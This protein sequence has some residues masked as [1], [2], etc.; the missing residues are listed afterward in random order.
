VC[1]CRGCPRR[2]GA[3]LGAAA[4]GDDVAGLVVDRGHAAFHQI[5]RPGDI[6]LVRGFEAVHNGLHVRVHA[7][8]DVHRHG[9]RII[10][11]Q[12]LGFVD[13]GV[14]VGLIGVAA[15]AGA[16]L[17]ARVDQQVFDLDRFRQLAFRLR[18]V[19]V[20]HHQVQ[21]RVAALGGQIQI[22][23]RI[24]VIGGVDDAGQHCALRQVQFRDGLAEVVFR[25]LLDAAD[26]AAAAEVQLVQIQFEDGFLVACLLQLH[27][28]RDLLDLVFNAFDPG[29]TGL[30]V[31]EIGH[32]DQLHREGG[33]AL[34]E[35]H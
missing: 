5:I 32:L 14:D 31:L 23:V 22:I 20:A 1:R 34:L 18:D 4:D 2:P 24:V 33:A 19:A 27:R 10:A 7:G 17:L 13:H 26:V 3:A 12:L 15:A 25:S 9:G 29:R 11:G 16:G 35:A 28:Q 21:H 6:R 30:V 8:I